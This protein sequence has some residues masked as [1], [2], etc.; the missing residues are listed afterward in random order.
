MYII[1]IE[2]VYKIQTKF[3]SFQKKDPLLFRGLFIVLQNQVFPCFHYLSKTT[4]SHLIK[5]CHIFLFRERGK[6][7]V[8]KLSHVP[9]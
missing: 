9:I 6:W 3:T 5:L 2:I 1:K 7:H 4:P 8:N